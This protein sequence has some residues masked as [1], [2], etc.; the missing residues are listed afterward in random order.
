[1]SHDEAYGYT[2]KGTTQDDVCLG[3]RVD[4]EVAHNAFKFIA[5]E[6]IHNPTRIGHKLRGRYK[7][8]GMRSVRRENFVIEFRVDEVRHQVVIHAVG[9]A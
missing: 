6:L 3:G 9:P 2:F 4:E 5:T 1:M 8:T 7:G